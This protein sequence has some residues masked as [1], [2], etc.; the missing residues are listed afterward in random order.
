MGERRSETTQTAG[1][2]GAGREAG[3]SP[4]EA[5]SQPTAGEKDGASDGTEDRTV[6]GRPD[7]PGHVPSVAV[8]PGELNGL[9]DQVDGDVDASAEDD[10]GEQAHQDEP[11][12]ELRSRDRDR[13]ARGR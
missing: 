7:R 1:E 12:R 13:Y 3:R 2:T 10:R 6:F 4:H 8:L 11:D 9:C 5:R